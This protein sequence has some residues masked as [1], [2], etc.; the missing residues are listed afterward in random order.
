M[1]G[2][3][4]GIGF[5]PFIYRLA[6]SHN[7]SGWVK[8]CDEGVVIHASGINSTLK[9]FLHQIVDQSPEAATIQKVLCYETNAVKMNGFKIINSKTTSKSKKLT[10]IG[11][12]IAVCQ[13]CLDDLKTQPHRTNYP[14]INCT[15]CGPRFSIIKD[16][17]YD[18]EQTTMEPFK[19]CLLC[20]EE[21]KNVNNRRFHAQPIACNNCGPNYKLKTPNDEMQDLNQIVEETASLIDFGKI[22]G[23]KGMGGFFIACDA[24]NQNSID[25]LRYL[26]NREN[27]PFAVMFR[28]V[29]KLNDQCFTDADELK[30][31]Q[32]WRRPVVIIKSKNKLPQNISNGLNSIGA[33]LPYMPFHYLLFEKLKTDAIVFTSGN[34]SDE[35]IIISNKIAQKKLPKICEAIITYN[36][37]IYNRTDDSVVKLIN[38][39]TQILRRSRGYAPTPLNSKLN[40][41]NILAVGG[42]LKNTFCIGRENSAILSQHIGDLKEPETLDFFSQNIN[43]FKKMFRVQ[44]ELIV[45]DLHPDYY[46]TRYAQETGLPTFAV[47]HHHAHIASCMAEHGLDED[48][49]GIAFDGTGF[50]DDGHIWGS[51]FFICN[52]KNYQQISHFEYL[53]L[54]GGDLAATEPWR[55]AIVYLYQIY[56]KDF[57]TLKLPII[58]NTSPEKIDWLLKAIGNNINCPLSSGA[59]RVFD[60]VSA[61]LG[62]CYYSTFEA[63]APIR[64]ENI[65]DHNEI[66]QYTYDVKNTI[67]FKESIKEIIVDIKNGTLPETIAGKFHNTI[68]AATSEKIVE[69]KKM[70]GLKKVVLSG[71]SFQNKILL[72]KTCK[73]LTNSGF[74]VYT[75]QHIPANDGGI[76]LGQLII[77]AKN[78]NHQY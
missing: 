43:Q 48:V 60:A 30:L 62:L 37:K 52:L 16:L 47:Q 74:K 44:P 23:I 57:H 20:D 77:A 50:G 31:L 14:L 70:S 56:G 24:F 49:I 61:L 17:P 64:L 72:E 9:T 1:H 32:S 13:N 3:V 6:H 78:R 34:F 40:V 66:K 27:K 63:E 12:D 7:L 22:A 33:L 76:S 73:K 71:G 69:I 53:P 75:H 19:M 28:N 8:N 45:H 21:Y 38:G 18:R 10:Q 65:A 29:E 26:K 59:G 4:Q 55:M 46:S 51:E 58:K 68:V 5:R 25:K 67:S 36:R 54:P 15:N 11:P 39:K 41:H 2:L 42:E 35:P